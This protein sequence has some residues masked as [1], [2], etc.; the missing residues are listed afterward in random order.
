MPLVTLTLREGKSVEFKTAVLGA[1]HQALV[2]SGVPEKDR[3]QRVLALAP[4]QRPIDPM[5]GIVIHDTAV[6]DSA[7]AHGV[8]GFD[9]RTR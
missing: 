1:V 7:L 6:A 3:F 2:N 9:G 8:D 4:W 5:E